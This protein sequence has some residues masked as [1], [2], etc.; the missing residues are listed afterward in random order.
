MFERFF[1]FIIP[2]R[3]SGLVRVLSFRRA[4]LS[5]MDHKNLICLFRREVLSYSLLSMRQSG[6]FCPPISF[7]YLSSPRHMSK[8]ATP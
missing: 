8:S 1:V 6:S 4:A 3:A 5:P 2:N 7:L